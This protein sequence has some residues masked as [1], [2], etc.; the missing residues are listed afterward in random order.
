[1]Q[2]QR[3]CYTLE[4]KL[5][6]IKLATGHN[7][8]I[9]AAQELG[10]S[11]ENIR[12]WKRQFEE[13]ILGSKTRQTTASKLLQL[14]RLKRELAEV[15]MERD[16][17]RKASSILFSP[18]HVKFEFIK[19]FKFV[20]PLEKICKILSVSRSG[21]H[22]WSQRKPSKRTLYNLALIEQIKK[23][24]Y[25]NKKRYGSPP[26]ARELKA[27]GINASEKLIR[28]L[29]KQASLE[30]IF[31]R[32]FKITT[33]SSHCYPV[34]ENK[35]DR[36]F[37][38]KD[39]NEVWVSDITYIRTAK[40][41]LYLTTVIDLFDRKVI[42]WSLSSTITA[43]NTSICAFRMA[44]ANRPIVNNTS[45]LF[46]SDRGIQYACGEF[47]REIENHRSVARS[48]SGKGNCWDN[49]VAESFFKTLKV[50]LIYQNY[51]QNKHEA[52]S[53]ISEYIEKFYN[54]NRRHKHLNNMNIL[55]YQ[56]LQ[57]KN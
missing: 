54:T 52:E 2:N 16:I 55:E 39:K 44:L 17:L 10:T 33:N 57:N 23:I 20:Y 27:I 42:G 51:F 28:K 4:F 31:K 48:M 37:T 32:K 8:T 15:K 7:K 1:M 19:Q 24:H 36:E 22:Y 46:H 49:A 43:R 38:V 11:A 53:S 21:F 47:V 12:R 26:I 34:V 5:Q 6:A 35:L 41:W 50:E 14:K 30:T 29:M 56:K 45:L 13:G 25:R 9:Q 18:T 3:Q 40:R